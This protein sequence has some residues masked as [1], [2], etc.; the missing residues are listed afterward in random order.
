MW[1]L[2]LLSFYSLSFSLELEELWKYALEKNP[3]LSSK[4]HALESAKWQLKA[5]EQA[6]FPELIGAYRL[7]WQS[8]RQ[9]IHLPAF[10]AFPPVKMEGSKDKYQSFQVGLRQVLY[11]GGFRKS[12]VDIS[13]SLL[14]VS[15]ED[16][17]EALFDVKLEVAKAYLSVLSSLDQLE[18]VRKQKHAVEEDLRQR[19]A[20][21]K[22]GLVAITEVLQVRVRLAEVERN[23]RQ[24]EGN[25][26]IVLANL[27]KL[28]G[29]E[30]EEL[31]H[32]KPIA[33]EVSELNLKEL[34]D[35]AISQRPAIK[36]AKERLRIEERKR[37]LELSSYYPK[38]FVEGFY[39]YSD[40]NPNLVSRGFFI[41]SL[42][43]SL[44]FQSLSGYYKALA[45]R[46]EE[47]R[48][49]EEL[50]ELIN[51]ISLS[52]KTAYERLLTARDNLRV[53]EEALRFAEEFYRL[54]LEQYRNQIISGT[55][56]IQAEA[57]LTQAR[58]AKVIAYYELI[59]AYFELLREVGEL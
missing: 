17:K 16:Y 24:A 36:I 7:S 55:E 53:A 27:S 38:V 57:S 22:E 15:Q 12:M 33:I 28:T 11:D 3:L 49:R 58:K 6:Y 59:K 43:L 51:S 13:K 21:Y 50:R 56:L 1:L 19:S 31:K 35:K 44:N 23:L 47:K 29:L 40:Q 48:A 2:I 46:E 26:R 45:Q 39:N 54:S 42:G 10:D 8:E 5:K 4:K 14:R 52:V 30:E 25:Y 37:G 9:S 18:V 20:F 32:V 34:T 41:L